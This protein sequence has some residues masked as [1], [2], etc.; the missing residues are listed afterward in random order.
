MSKQ[1]VKHA[2]QMG[3]GYLAIFIIYLATFTST[4]ILVGKAI[5]GTQVNAT[6]QKTQSISRSEGF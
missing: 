5:D 1:Q 2:V 6:T 4:Y 3:T